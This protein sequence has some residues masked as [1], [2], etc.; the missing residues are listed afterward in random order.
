M[1][2]DW[3][4]YVR[5]HLPPL[6]I[7]PERE[8]EI[9]E[10][11]A[12]HLEATYRDALANGASEREA[13]KLAAALFAD[14]RLMEC[15]LSRAERPVNGAALRQLD[16]A[17]EQSQS[18]KSRRRLVRME[19]LLRDLRFGLRALL[20]TPGFTLIAVITLSLGIGVNTAIFSSIDALLLRPLDFPDL[21]RLV[22]L[23]ETPDEGFGLGNVAPA[24]FL[25]WKG[26]SAVFD[27]M[28]VYQWWE[29]DLTG[30]GEP[31]RLRGGRVSPGF[32]HM[33][34]VKAALGRTFTPDEEQPGRDRVAVI[35]YGLWQRR[36]AAD[37][38][39]VGTT[40]RLSG[41][42]F[43]VVG[44][45]PPGFDFP[46]AT[47]VWAPLPLTGEFT[48]ERKSQ[49]L[50]VIARLKPAITTAQAQAEMDA[51][52]SR[53]EQL[54][55]ETNTGRRVVVTLLRDRVVGGFTPMY[56]WFSMGAVLFV[57]LIA[58]V[59]IANMQLARGAGRFS[60]MAIRAAM[61]ATRWRIIRQLLTENALLALLGGALG[62]LMAVWMLAL[63]KTSFPSEITRFIPGYSR[64][65]IDTQ[66]L[67]FT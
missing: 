15:E 55:P 18:E 30:V 5:D 63:M 32:F 61:G 34:G 62:I 29:S 56:L 27:S 40:I 22:A 23:S 2:P 10:E 59:N 41:A 66:A 4:I 12:A 42:R 60:E 67:S 64:L 7:E 37:P 54:H 25:D 52:A 35:S 50:A 43:T 6:A 20:K 44:V 17:I 38:H 1:M 9:I 53:L 51:I 3:K 8:M 45:M 58:C 57:L 46:K 19:T 13:Y 28:A 49:Y 36:F 39:I 33:L 26:Q 31:E 21:E 14:W 24:D 47:A 16:T 65:A 11:L 48:S